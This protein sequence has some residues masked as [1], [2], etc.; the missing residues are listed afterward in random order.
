MEDFLLLLRFTTRSPSLLLNHK[1]EDETNQQF[2]GF[3]CVFIDPV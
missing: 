1:G 3:L 2:F